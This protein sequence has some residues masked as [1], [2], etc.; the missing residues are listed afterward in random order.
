MSPELLLSTKFG[1]EKGVPSKEADIYAL[2]MTVYQVLIGK[3]PFCPKW[4]AELLA[5]VISG[6]R[7]PKPE[8]AER[9]GMTDAVWALLVECWREDRATR[10]NIS[11]VLRRVCH[12]TGER[13]T[14]D[15]MI[16]MAG[17]HLNITGGN[18]GS[19]HSGSTLVNCE[20]LYSPFEYPCPILQQRTHATRWGTYFSSRLFRHRRTVCHLRDGLDYRNVDKKRPS[21]PPWKLLMKIIWKKR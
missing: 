13:R 21:F 6:E 1:L 7:P 4:E 12:I 16:G 11:D 18:R 15:S 14:T 9:I 5:A 17:L 20:W 8:N 10:P 3:G 2:G 19:I